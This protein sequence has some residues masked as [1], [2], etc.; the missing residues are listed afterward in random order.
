[1][2]AAL[3][4]YLHPPQMVVLRGDAAGIE[5]WR[6]E[7]DRFY[8]PSRMLFAI[9]S[10]AMG[11]PPALADRRPPVTAAGARPAAHPRNGAHDAVIAYLCQGSHCSAPIAS[12][13][14]LVRHLR[15]QLD[16]IPEDRS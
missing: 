9:P 11:L 2:L 10:D 1:M 7:L 4:D 8:A 6:G 13:P 12:L 5:H 3:E 15:L 14:E 16:S